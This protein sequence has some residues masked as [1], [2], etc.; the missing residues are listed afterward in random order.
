M[1]SAAH[2]IVHQ[3]IP[4]YKCNHARS[5]TSTNPDSLVCDFMEDRINFTLFFCKRNSLKPEV[6]RGIFG[7]VG[8]V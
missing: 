5:G 2:D 1:Y 7:G 8:V 6:R 4:V 3:I